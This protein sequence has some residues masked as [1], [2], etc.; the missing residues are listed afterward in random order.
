MVQI[1][2]AQ[3]DIHYTDTLYIYD[4]PDTSSP[5]IGAFNSFTT[6]NLYLSLI[7][8]SLTNASGCLTV[9]FV[10]DGTTQATGWN[11]TI[12]CAPVC[13]EIVASLNPALTNP[14]SDTNYIVICPGQE[15]TFS[16]SADYVENDMVY[17]QDDATSTYIW[18]F[19]DGTSA[20]GQTVD[21]T[22]G[23][24]GGYTVTLYIE[25]VN[26][27]VNT[28][29]IETRIA[30][31]GNPFN[32]IILPAD[33]CANDTAHLV[34][35]SDSGQTIEGTPFYSEI[36]TTLGVSD[37]TFLPDGTGT[38]YETSVI[39]NCFAPGQ[40]LDNPQDFF[41]L[42][43]NMEHSFLGDLGISLICP[44]GQTLLLHEFT[45]GGSGGGTFLG[46]PI[47]DDAILDP[48]TGEYYSWTPIT[49]TY[50]TMTDE[51][52]AVSTLLTGSYTP[53]GSFADLV[54]CPL[55]GE[56][57][58]EI[59]DNW[60]SDN[61]YIFGWSMTL[62]PLIAPDT[63]SYTVPIDQQGWTTGPYIISSNDTSAQVVAPDAGI[64]TYGYTIIDHYGCQW[65]TTTTLT[66]IEA[67]N[68][69]L[70]N[71]IVICDSNTVVTLDAG[72]ATSY[73]WDN[74]STSQ[75]LNVNQAGT[76]VVTAT[77][78][79]C[80]ATDNVEIS[81]HQGFQ[82]DNDSSDVNCFNGFDGE[83]SVFA[84]SA[85]PPTEYAWSNL[86]TSSTISS[87]PIGS[88]T[89]T[90]TD[91]LGCTVT[92]TIS[93]TEP[94]KLEETYVISPVSCFGDDDGLIDLSVNGGVLPYSY[95]WSTGNTSQDISNIFA[96]HYYVTIIDANGCKIT[97]TMNI[98][99]PND[100]VVS[101]PNDFTVCKSVQYNLQSSI[102][103][104]ANPYT[105]AWNSGETSANIDYTINAE[106][107]YSL[108][109]TDDHGCTG[110]NDV[111]ISVYDDL[112]LTAVA[113]NSIV[114]KGDPVNISGSI[115]GG[116]L[117]YTT[118]INNSITL[119]P[120]TVYV[121]NDENYTIHVVDACGYTATEIIGLNTYPVPSLSF[122]ADIL[123]DCPPFNVNFNLASY[124]ITSVY[125]WSFGDGGGSYNSNNPSYTY[126]N[127]GVFDVSV[128][129]IDENGCKNNLTIE[130]LINVYPTPDAKFAPNHSVVTFINPVI[131]F[132]N[133]S[134]GN[135]NNYWDL[136]DGSLSNMIN[137]SH[138]YQEIGDYK[139]ILIVENSYGCLDTAIDVVTVQDAYTLYVP[140][141]FS[142]DADGI[143]DFF[144]LKGHGIDADNFL[145]QIYDRWGEI[146][147]ETTDI[148]EGW[149]GIAKNKRESQS[150]TYTWMVVCK[151]FTGEEH[152]KS[153]VVTIIR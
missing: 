65:D 148:Y 16:G 97:E 59:C 117:P 23:D 125:N 72:N 121:S 56:W 1:Y 39:F 25:D 58:I 93:I 44:N 60:G 98:I 12:Q 50:G 127:S 57:T 112:L 70:G 147:W 95:S 2:F 19:G 132:N 138:K 29:S 20:I 140:T 15:I 76:Y 135:D 9:R 86:E 110:F 149:D 11:A 7:E 64:Y 151:D 83:V 136:G 21:H 79:L 96:G 14:A 113:D 92:Q 54:G 104:G 106:T 146:I 134:L 114:C 153:G 152:T 87:L 13:Q 4:G 46:V 101:L 37:T 51:S 100:V 36:T 32:Q 105:Y 73:I 89:V 67:P 124:E 18:F 68:L 41:S 55:N 150:G 27:C 122:S 61:G 38:C 84:T 34:Y 81:L 49:P 102:T 126:E 118:Y 24:I 22:Y 26:G 77:I 139:I 10:S 91:Q 30:I 71:D 47:D 94:P 133:Y 109:V 74:G 33:V 53:D 99:Q 35:A 45:N 129:V 144:V 3:T 116:L 123:Q 142:P 85:F 141:A 6:P 78:G 131:D 128:D 120:A 90:V 103:G 107:I 82:L 43:I 5:L 52:A 31:A 137:P 28:N 66:V 115:S 143:N 88:Y 48:G 130:K 40:T 42:D 17:H 75:T 69:N 80:W 62:N 145:L 111:T 108:T 63:W 119:L 8:A